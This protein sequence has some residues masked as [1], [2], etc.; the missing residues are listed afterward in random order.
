MLHAK[1]ILP[2]GVTF[3]CDFLASSIGVFKAVSFYPNTGAENVWKKK[4]RGNRQ[5]RKHAYYIPIVCESSKPILPTVRRRTQRVLVAPYSLILLPC[6]C[7]VVKHWLSKYYTRVK[8]DHAIDVTS[9]ELTGTPGQ[10]ASA[11]LPKNSEIFPEMFF[12][13][14]Q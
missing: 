11:S 13:K 5:M 7:V 2:I 14:E 10:V 9:K 8:Q 12:S 4:A 1:A 3:T 6:T